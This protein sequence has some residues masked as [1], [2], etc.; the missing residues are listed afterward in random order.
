M[1]DIQNL[2]GT[3]IRGE[4]RVYSDFFSDNNIIQQTAIVAPKSLIIDGLR[5]VFSKDNIFTYRT[6]EFGY[7]LTID[8]TGKEIDSEDTTKILISDAYRYEMKFFPA[9]IIKSNGGT[10][11]PLSFN[12]NM[13]YKYRRDLVT[14]EYGATRTVSTPTHRVYTGLWDMNFDIGIYSESYSELEELVDIVSIAL[15]YTLWNELRE[16]GLFIK[17][18]TISGESAEPYAN[19]YIYSQNI[20][21]N[22]HSEWRA[23]IPLDN[24][25][26]KLV[27]FF[28]SVMH[29]I[30]GKKAASD[31]LSMNY[32]D[33]LQLAEL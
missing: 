7:P 32:N 11:K 16:N 18:L 21:I 1:I 15:Q 8:L 3:G 26:E 17:R 2:P 30:P 31:V 28:D 4:H 12:Q 29:P 25:I 23:E 33:I 5:G 27:F 14:D 19:D 13:T 9:I 6:D 24:V 10:Y 20:S 22:T